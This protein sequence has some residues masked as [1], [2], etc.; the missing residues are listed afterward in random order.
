MNTVKKLLEMCIVS[1]LPWI[2][3]LP[4]GNS[5]ALKI[6]IKTNSFKN[7]NFSHRNQQ[8]RRDGGVALRSCYFCDISGLQ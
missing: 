5:I 1:T 4:S 2:Y 3:C 8:S 6:S 7:I